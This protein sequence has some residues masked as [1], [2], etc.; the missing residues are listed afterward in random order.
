MPKP[1]SF[2]DDGYGDCEDCNL[3]F[4]NPV[5][6]VGT[7]PVNAPD[8]VITPHQSAT[9]QA[10]GEAARLR[11]GTLK[12]QAYGLI[13]NAPGG[14]TCEEIELALARSHQ[15]VSSAVNSLVRNGHI[16]PMLQPTGGPLQRQNKSGHFATV[17]MP[18]RA[19]Q[20][21]VA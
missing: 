8:P 18:V 15:S 11:S 7:V 17:W 9:S 1:H 10:A 6:Q 16:R 13:A 20:Q 5:H 3:P 12:A 19:A 14:A 2:N 21:V 4:P